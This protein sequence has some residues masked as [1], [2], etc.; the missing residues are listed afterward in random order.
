MR[1][2]ENFSPLFLDVARKA[3]LSPQHIS[4]PD[5]GTA[6]RLQAQFNKLRAAMRTEHHALLPL[7]ERVGTRTSKKDDTSHWVEFTQADYATEE[8]LKK[9]G[10]TLG[11]IE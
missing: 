3:I 10:Y 6:K 4:T 9:A 11:D 8:I 2:S 5:W 1:K 7:M